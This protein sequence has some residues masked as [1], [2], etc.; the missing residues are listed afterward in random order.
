[1]TQPQPKRSK[2]LK[3]AVAF[4]IVCSPVLPGPVPAAKA[5]VA[6]TDTIRVA[7]YI[8]S[9]KY[10]LSVPAVTVTTDG[11]L[12]IGFRQAAGPTIVPDGAPSALRASLDQYGVLLMETDQYAAAKAYY[13]KLVKAGYSSTLFAAAKQGKEVYQVGIGGYADAA[14]AAAARDKVKADSSLAASASA[15]SLTG[16]LR[17]S[18]GTYSTEAEASARV[19]EL[20]QAG[21]PAVL[22]YHEDGAGNPAFSAWIGQEADQTGMAAIQAQAL[23]VMPQLAL[24]QVDTSQPYAVK[25]DD[26]TQGMGETLPHLQFNAGS[27]LWISSSQQSRIK[28]TEKDNRSYRGS[29]ELSQYGG[30]LAVVNEL[31][32]EHYLYSVVSTEMGQGWPMEA[33]KA[34]AVTA[35]SYALEKGMKY[36]IAHV[37]DSTIDQAYNGVEFDD[38]IEAVNATAGEVM[39]M[40][41]GIF[42]PLFYSNGGGI[43][44]ES[45]E[46]WGN[47]APNYASVNSPDSIAEKGKLTWYFV[48]LP[49][50]KTG[51]IRSD[52]LKDT[53]SKNAAGM[54]YYEPTENGVN[55]R[56]FPDT[57]RASAVDKVNQGDRIVVL[58][59]VIES[60]AYSWIRGTYTSAEMTGIM[61]KQLAEPLAGPV[62]SLEVSKRGPSG[63]ALEIKANGQAVRVQY[64]DAIRTLMGGLPSTLFE[65]EETGRYTILGANDVS[66]TYPESALSLYAVQGGSPSAVLPNEFLVL[67]GAGDVRLATKD[68]KFIFRGKGN[69]HGL[70]MSQWGARGLAEQ[71]Y[72]Y[73]KILEHYYKGVTITKD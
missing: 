41:K 72:D 18:A 56:S 69:G 45:E 25:R 60:N 71:G 1:M 16:P 40:G 5:S 47:P 8:E 65:I 4:S 54:S 33:L 49:N 9:P 57:N 66:R 22:A 37:T 36:E 61:N 27:K 67:N 70:G 15:Q 68:Q 29:L 34:Q 3:W 2:W 59:E 64:P 50:G 14:L 58:D 30:K 12:S 7:L 21:L 11:G 31:P 19:T 62:R 51:Y 23:Q 10:K 26:R 6:T 17:W 42:S 13:D 32:L 52:L 20:Q 48:W 53:G 44:A 73:K 55:V 46:V 43:T 63:R 28:V 35:R 39:V 24:V 38:V